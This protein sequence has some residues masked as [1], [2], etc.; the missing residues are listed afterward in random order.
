MTEPFPT[1]DVIR[2]LLRFKWLVLGLTLVTTIGVYIYARTLPEY[3]KATVNC[4]PPSSDVGGLGSALGGISSTLKD[5]GLSKLGGKTSESYEFITILFTRTIRDSMIKRFDLVKEYEME[6]QPMKDVRIEFDAN[7][8][9]NLHTEGNY[10][11]SIWSRDPQKA[12]TMCDAFVSYANEITN[13]IQRAEAEKSAEYMEK[14]LDVMD[15]VLSSLTDSLGRYSRDYRLFSPLDQAAASADALAE[16]KGELLKQETILGLLEH[17]YGANDPQV[18]STKALVEQLR[19]QYEKSQ[20]Q[21]GFAGNFAL[22]DAAG[23]G[24]RYM[25]IF[26][27]FEGY[28]KLKAFLLPSLE[29]ARLDMHKSAP[30][31]IVIDAPIPAEKRDRPKRLFMAA[32]AGLGVLILTLLFLLAMRGWK[33]MMQKRNEIV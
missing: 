2:Y 32:G 30:S 31:L 15:S 22:T 13:R 12:V 24:A 29:Q 20:T 11:I 7:L 27:E 18:R 10:E 19:V 9:V 4:V 26:A 3:F 25:L 28:T 6:D 16:A 8:E 1:A 14:R 5:I 21:K 17:N 33:S 23:I